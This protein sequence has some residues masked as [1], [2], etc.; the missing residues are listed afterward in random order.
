MA[1]RQETW[2]SREERI[3]GR[4]VWPPI[5]DGAMTLTAAQ[6]AVLLDGC[7]WRM[8]ARTW[9]PEMAG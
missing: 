4:F 5:V 8:P 2:L 9:R 3:N 6:L 7:E 1:G